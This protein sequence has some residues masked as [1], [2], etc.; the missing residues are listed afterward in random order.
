[1]IL[2]YIRQIERDGIDLIDIGSS[3]ALDDKWTAIKEL[4]N[5]VGFDPNTEECNRQNHLP[6]QYRKSV[7]L[8]YAVHGKSGE[9]V[10]HRTK[11][12]FCFSL[13]KPNKPWLDRFSFYELFTVEAEE[14]ISVCAI[15]EIEE[16]KSI[17]PDAIK[18]DVQGLELPILSKAGRLLESAF[19]VETETGFTSN[20][21]GETTFFQLGAF[22][23]SKGFLMFDIN[24]DHRISRNNPLECHKTGKEQ[25][26]WAEAVWLRD[27]VSLEQQGKFDALGVDATKAKK[28]LILCALEK[29]YDFGYELAELFS[30]KGLLSRRELD[31]LAN[32][33][34]WNVIQMP[35]SLVSKAPGLDAPSY[36]IKLIAS[37]LDL[38]PSRLRNAIK[39]A[40]S[41]S[42]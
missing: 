37:L 27:Y 25:I 19:Y 23:Q 17:S 11:S 26:L 6:S 3:G 18:I 20:Y 4:I 38:L 34:A 29:C 42:R 41:R 31:A 9:E 15:D 32:V 1:M 16:L 40:L 39:L 22:M 21:V 30:A 7:F 24:T 33:D 14:P 36:K 28:V 12:I 10:L 2:D 8:P 35:N 13:L 5:L